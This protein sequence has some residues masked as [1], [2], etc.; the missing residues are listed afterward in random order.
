MNT[1][2]HQNGLSLIE[3]DGKRLE[4]FL[5]PELSFQYDDIQYHENT[6][7]YVLDGHWNDFTV[8]QMQELDSYI[9]A[10]EEDPQGIINLEALSYLSSTDWYVVRKFET[11]AAIP[12]DVLI[13]RAEARAAIVTTDED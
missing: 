2:I 10:Q 8:E 7:G 5:K 6:K 4:A 13:K 12:Q 1:F 3:K 9:T 11:G